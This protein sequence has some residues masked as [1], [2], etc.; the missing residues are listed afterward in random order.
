MGA[1]RSYATLR[2]NRLSNAK[3]GSTWD[4]Q[5]HHAGNCPTRSALCCVKWWGLSALMAVLVGSAT[6]W[7]SSDNGLVVPKVRTR[8]W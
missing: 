5:S 3:A 7:I 2:R 8:A 6:H 1:R 4:L